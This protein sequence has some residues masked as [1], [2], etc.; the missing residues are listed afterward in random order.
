M[1]RCYERAALAL[2]LGSQHDGIG[3]DSPYRSR[4]ALYAAPLQPE[5]ITLRQRNGTSLS[6]RPRISECACSLPPS[7][8]DTPC[9]VDITSRSMQILAALDRRIN[10]LPAPT[11]TA[12]CLDALCLATR[13]CYSVCRN[14]RLIRPALTLSSLGI[15]CCR[16]PHPASLSFTFQKSCVRP[17]IS[18]VSCAT[19][20]A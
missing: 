12:L 9:N 18:L 19:Y 7:I 15:S 17:A 11:K 6:S 13:S 3:G 10:D 8:R 5:I 16:Q 4:A 20:P 2:L 1:R 14:V